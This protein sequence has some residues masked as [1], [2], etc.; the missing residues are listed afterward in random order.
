MSMDLIM[1]DK[2][3]VMIASNVSFTSE[4]TR[5]DLHVRKKLLLVSYSGQAEP[6]LLNIEVHDRMMTALRSASS[7]LVVELS[8]GDITGGFDVPLVQYEFSPD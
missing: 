3:D 1:S 6:D 7:V 4:V 5:I 8:G 2:G